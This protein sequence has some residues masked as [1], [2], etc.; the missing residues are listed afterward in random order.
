MAISLSRVFNPDSG[1]YKGDFHAHTSYS[2]GGF[3]PRDLS[4]LAAQQ[5]LDF[6][7]ITDHNDLRAFDDFDESLERMVLPGLE[8]TLHEGHFNVFGIDGNT[9]PARELLR[10]IVDLPNK[11]RNSLSIPHAQLDELL[12][13]LTAMGLFISVN[14]PMLKPWGW[15]DLETHVNCFGGIELINDPTFPGNRQATPAAL[16]LWN[17]WLNAGFRTT[18]IGGTD[19]HSS[20]PWDNPQRISRLDLP[21]TCVY[22]QNLSCLAVLEGLRQRHAYISLGPVIDFKAS[23]AGKEYRMGDDLG[24]I[25]SLATLNARVSN[26]PATA[27]AVIVKNGSVVAESPVESGEARLELEVLPD[28]TSGWFRFD[29]IDSE[30]QLLAISNPIFIGQTSLSKKSTFGD[31]LQ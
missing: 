11:Q 5:G 25:K 14:H 12:D 26:C 13:R 27:Q 15:R 29:V 30:G 3:K 7:S 4:E 21:F 20:R 1:W 23:L 6:L 17:A 9:W 16:H 19:F 28:G 22:A 24:K 18:A 2:D 8:V 31:F 10:G